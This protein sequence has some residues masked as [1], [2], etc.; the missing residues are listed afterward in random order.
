MRSL[1]Q[2]PLMS[3]FLFS[4]LF[5]LIQTEEQGALGI[6]LLTQGAR[7]MT[8]CKCNVVEYTCLKDS[9]DLLRLLGFLKGAVLD[10]S[11]LNGLG[12]FTVKIEWL[13]FVISLPIPCSQLFTESVLGAA[14]RNDLGCT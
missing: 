1:Y 13:H 2:P 14:F 4:L 11:L 3:P 12:G 9:Q 8:T 5:L 10:L 7:G 6:V